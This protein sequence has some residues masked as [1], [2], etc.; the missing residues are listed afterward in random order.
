VAAVGNPGA[1]VTQM[2]FCRDAHGDGLQTAADT[3]A[4][5]GTNAISVTVADVLDRRLGDR[6]I[7]PVRPGHRQPRMPDVVRRV[8]TLLWNWRRVLAV[9]GRAGTPGTTQAVRS[10]GRKGGL[11]D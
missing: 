2:A 4:G 9:G 7:H 1:T 11:A 6:G 5:Y 8:P 10:T 3:M